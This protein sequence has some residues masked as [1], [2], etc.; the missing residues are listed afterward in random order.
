M[1]RW[2]NGKGQKS[3][4][5]HSRAVL[6]SF[7]WICGFFC[8]VHFRGTIARW[9]FLL[10]FRAYGIGYEGLIK[11]NIPQGFIDKRIS[12]KFRRSEKTRSKFRSRWIL[13][14]HTCLS[15]FEPFRTVLRRIDCF[16]HNCSLYFSFS[17]LKLFKSINLC[18]FFFQYFVTKICRI[19]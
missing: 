12:T 15:N 9:N 8:A 3:R 19:R 11:T 1:G 4:G 7:L 13:T 6:R 14:V 5:F 17:I 18:V 10:I 2:K 16:H